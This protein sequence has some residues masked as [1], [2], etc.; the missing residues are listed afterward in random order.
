MDKGQKLCKNE[1]KGKM[2]ILHQNGRS[3]F[4]NTWW[5]ISLKNQ[6]LNFDGFGIALKE[7]EMKICKK[8]IFGSFWKKF[9][10]GNFDFRGVFWLLQK[11]VCFLEKAISRKIVA[12]FQSFKQAQDHP[13]PTL[14]VPPNILNKLLS[15]NPTL[16]R[17]GEVN[18]FNLVTYFS[19]YKY[20]PC[21]SII[22]Q[23]SRPRATIIFSSFAL[24]FAFSSS[25][26]LFSTNKLLIIYW[27]F[28][29]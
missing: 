6:I 16:T 27:R 4:L 15:K 11:S 8:V 17:R 29:Y 24:V 1:T 10:F 21:G 3:H 22:T 13:K 19:L 28:K 20:Q 12:S 18:K 5:I 9:I 14:F 26:L 7:F 25:F 2:V 23:F